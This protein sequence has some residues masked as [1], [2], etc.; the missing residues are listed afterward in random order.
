MNQRGLRSLPQFVLFCLAISHVY[1]PPLQAS[2]VG[3]L[4]LKKRTD[5]SV[6]LVVT[7]NDA[8]KI[9]DANIHRPYRIKWNTNP[10]DTSLVSGATREFPEFT[11]GVLRPDTSYF[12][13]V[14]AYT[15]RRQG[16][17][18]KMYRKVGSITFNT[19]PASASYCPPATWYDG[20]H[21]AYYDGANCNVANLSLYGIPFI[22]DGSYYLSSLSGPACPVTLCTCP[23]GSFDGANCFIVVKPATGFI[24][25]NGFYQT[26]GPGYS[27]PSGWAFDGANCFLMGAPWGTTA[28][29]YQGRFYTTR[30]PYCQ[31]GLFDGANCYLGKPPAGR[32]PFIYHGGFYYQ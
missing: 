18:L 9:V 14:E 25:Q 12:M 2:T 21:A 11:I 19:M 27:C 3:T 24:W 23:V 30:L 10:I 31:F 22:Y 26:A 15:Q 29:E 13:T 5:T 6:T 20:T 16:I 32:A 17:S 7:L 8:F 28:F 4:T 1:A